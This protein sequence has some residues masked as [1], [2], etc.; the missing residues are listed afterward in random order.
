LSVRQADFPRFQ[1]AFELTLRELLSAEQL[2]QRL[3][4]D[5][6]LGAGEMTL[7]LAQSIADIAWGQGFPAPRFHGL[8]R[9]DEQRVVGGGHLKLVLGQ[10]GGRR[11]TVFDAMLFRHADALPEHI[12]AVYRL[13]VNEWNGLRALQLLLDYWEPAPV[14]TPLAS[15]RSAPPHAALS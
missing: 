6:T 7:Q 10:T 14:E 13:D 3:A 1:R 4:T 15:H 11:A 12:R 9:V 5:G 2:E 8:F